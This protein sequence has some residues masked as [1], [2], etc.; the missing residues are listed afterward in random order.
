M[1]MSTGHDEQPGTGIGPLTEVPVYVGILRATAELLELLAEFFANADV[2][3]R[4]QLGR[5]I[6][7]RQPDSIDPAIEAA[8]TMQELTE[9]ADLLHDLTG[10][11]SHT[12]TPPATPTRT[13]PQTR[14]TL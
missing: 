11:S 5:F 8:I 1:T 6:A 12:P 13:F 14:T 4:T 3:V 2:A 10:H 9:A 7:G